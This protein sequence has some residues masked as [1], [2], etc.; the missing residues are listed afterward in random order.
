MVT[1]P[2]TH[3]AYEDTISD[4][5]E[6][7][8]D[9]G[10]QVYVDGANLNALL[11]YANPGEFG[12]DVSHLNL[13]KTFC[14]PHGGG[15]PGVGPVGV[16][17]HLAPYLPTHGMHPEADKRSGIGP[18]SAAPYGS[19]GILPISW[20]YVRMMGA[21]GLTQATAV[22][23]LA[24][25]YVAERLQ[26]HFPV[27]YRGHNDRVAH[28][29][30]LDLRGL[31]KASGVTVDDVAKRL[32]D[33]G[34]HAPT[35]SFPVAG[36]LMVEPTESED[37][38][39]L[40]RF[41]EAMIAIRGE[42]DKVEA[43]GVDRRGLAAARCTAHR[44]VSAGRR[45]R[46]APTR[47]RS[48]CSRPGPDPDK[49]WPPV[50]RIDQAYGDRNL[51]CACPPPEA[52]AVRRN[53][54]VRT[55][56]RSSTAT[57]PSGGCPRSSPGC[58]TAP[59]WR[60]RARPGAET[61]TDTQFRIGSI[62]KTMT[63]VLVMQCR[64]DGLLDLD[65]PIKRFVPETGY[66]SATVRS[67]LAH[68]SGM[69]SEP[70]GPWWERSPGVPVEDLLAANDGSRAVFGPGEHYHYSNLGYALLGEAVAR[71]R[72]QS[73]VLAGAGAGARSARDDAHVVPPGG[74]VRHRAQ[75]APPR[76][77][78]DRG[79]AA[80]HRL[81][82]AGRSAVEHARG[83]SPASRRSWPGAT[84]TSWPTGRSPRC[85]SRCRRPSTTGSA[86]ACCRTPT[87]CSP[88]TPARCRGSRPLL[89]ADPLNQV[90]V[91]ALTNATTGFSGPELALALLGDHTP[92]RDRSRGCPPRRCRRGRASC[93]ATGT[94]ATP[95]TRSA[96]TTSGSSGATSPAA[97]SPSSSASARAGSSA[98]RATTTARPCTSYAVTTGRSTTSS[99]RRFV[100]TREPYPRRPLSVR[101]PAQSAWETELMLKS[102]TRSAGVAVR[103]KSSSPHSREKLGTVCEA[104]V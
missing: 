83:R 66:A 38:A 93:S 79:A 26:D 14:I 28:E 68:V 44:R 43:G 82:G 94:G 42:I 16:R 102:G 56:R 100:Y 33:Y 15:G 32:I 50:G 96:G 103:E 60:G 97:R 92:G 13:H 64:D 89:F 5:C 63:A 2:S 57:R 61:T 36:T 95:P 20:A 41:C 12:G 77:H 7:V 10:G 6:M 11:G 48:R 51:V 75:R 35:M 72:G 73:V 39:E 9:A 59:S 70:V 19:A 25:N 69:Q 31:T 29:C 84:R 104:C 81:D 27:L 53:R 1:Y 52:F 74:A 87:A 18:I 21:E 46:S 3:G 86:S 49:Y 34:F 78:P 91:V 47:P 4:L 54:L 80:R 65:D 23:V 22:A 58:S 98:S 24:A 62:T 55:S 40:D 45:R 8:H 30:I 99:A 101:D 85:G 76:G 90:G 71:L 37:L 88:A 67:L 17:E